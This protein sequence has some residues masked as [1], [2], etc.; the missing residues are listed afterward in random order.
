MHQLGSSVQ[1]V[2]NRLLM[3]MNK[4][5]LFFR[6]LLCLVRIQDIN[7]IGVMLSEVH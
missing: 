7:K 5:R 3:N 1:K 4:H 6:L 2:D